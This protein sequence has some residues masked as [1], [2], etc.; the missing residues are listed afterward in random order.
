[1]QISGS[2][3]SLIEADGMIS[4]CSRFC[5]AIILVMLCF[6]GFFVQS[7]NAQLPSN[8]PWPGSNVN[9]QGVIVQPGIAVAS[10]GTLTSLATANRLTGYYVGDF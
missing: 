6:A 5:L 9:G 4:R 10:C 7:I 2:K 8:P 3:G 1:M